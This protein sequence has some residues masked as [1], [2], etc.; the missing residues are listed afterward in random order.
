[1]VGRSS[2]TAQIVTA[3]PHTTTPLEV[4]GAWAVSVSM[5]IYFRDLTQLLQAIEPLSLSELSDS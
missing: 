1:M 2:R 3:L 4:Q 5:S